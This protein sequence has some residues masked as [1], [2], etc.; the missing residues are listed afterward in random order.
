MLELCTPSL[1][2]RATAASE[3]LKVSSI[4]STSKFAAEWTASSTAP[5]AACFAEQPVADAA[6]SGAQQPTSKDAS[7]LWRLVTAELPGWRE[8]TSPPEEPGVMPQN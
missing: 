4:P 8:E 7:S 2:G 6:A 5:S 3:S 1:V